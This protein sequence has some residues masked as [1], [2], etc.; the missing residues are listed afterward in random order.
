MKIPLHVAL[1]EKNWTDYWKGHHLLVRSVDKNPA[2]QVTLLPSQVNIRNDSL[3]V[4]YFLEVWYLSPPPFPFDTSPL[5]RS[6]LILQT[7]TTNCF[8]RETLNMS[9][10]RKPYSY[11]W[12]R[13]K[14]YRPG[15]LYQL[16][17]IDSKD[18]IELFS[19]NR[20]MWCNQP[21]RRQ[22][23]LDFLLNRSKQSFSALLGIFSSV[24]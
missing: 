6:S 4:W 13:W 14:S 24:K 16:V 23:F 9:C 15:R 12:T 8:T 17:F 5:P 11:K 18:S 21:V 22:P 20:A 2:E 3:Q 19:S 1:K 7:N 10:F